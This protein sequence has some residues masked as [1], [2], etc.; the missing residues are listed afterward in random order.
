MMSQLPLQHQVALVT[1]ASSGI[2]EAIARCM[3]EA[4]AAVGVNYSRDLA[5]A[6]AVVNDVKKSGGSAIAI[7]TDVRKVPASVWHNRYSCKQR[8]NSTGRCF[9][10]YDARAV[11]TRHKRQSHRTIP[12]LA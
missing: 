6:E 9:S 2:G 7:Q 10:R 4:G 11:G 1:G 3:A 12:V 5:G 8:W